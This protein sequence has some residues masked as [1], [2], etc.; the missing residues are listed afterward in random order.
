[1]GPRLLTLSG[2][3]G[4]GIVL[5]TSAGFRSH[6]LQ[7]LWDFLIMDPAQSSG[8]KILQ[9]FKTLLLAPFLW[10]RYNFSS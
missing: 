3:D 9:R 8:M 4:G 7:D 5:S 2:L 1:M 6:G 10:A